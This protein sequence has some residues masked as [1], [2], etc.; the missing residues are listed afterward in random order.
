MTLT[1]SEK[2]AWSE[3]VLLRPQHFQQLDRYHESLLS[4]RLNAIDALNWGVL[5]V[6]LDE[7]ALQ[8]GVVAL[9][10]FTGVLP[11]GTPVTID[12]ATAPESLKQRSVLEHFPAAQRSL[13]VHLAVPHER[14]GVTNYAEEGDQLRYALLARNVPDSARDDR[15]AEIQVAV[16][17]VCILLGDEA[18][19]GFTSVSITEIVRDK[20]GGFKVSP[21]YVPPCLRISGSHAIGSRL[22]QLLTKMVGRYRVLCNTRRIT[23]EGRVEFNAAD[24]TRYLQ[25]HALNTM[26]PTMFHLSTT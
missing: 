14:P 4:A 3:G 26:L 16:P 20:D 12:P 21:T 22:E 17:N 25:L 19:D 8:K 24:V 9:L 15:H 13:R 5:H 2:V 6:E 10:S 7:L 18:R 23:G 11:D 1:I